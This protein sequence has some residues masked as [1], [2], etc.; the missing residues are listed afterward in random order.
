LCGLDILLYHEQC[1][2]PYPG[3]YIL[4]TLLDRG[5]VPVETKRKRADEN[6]WFQPFNVTDPNIRKYYRH[7]IIIR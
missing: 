7:V 2:F 1:L 3:N 5:H 6:V 4:Y